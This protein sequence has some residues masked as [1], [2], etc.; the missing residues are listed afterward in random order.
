M[1]SAWLGLAGAIQFETEHSLNAPQLQSS[2][3]IV[4]WLPKAAAA[5][6][7]ITLCLCFF[8]CGP[9][10]ASVPHSSASGVKLRALDPTNAA[11]LIERQALEIM[12]GISP[13]RMFESW[14]VDREFGWPYTSAKQGASYSGL[15]LNSRIV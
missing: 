2:K 8:T 14:V 5:E 11:R 6:R 15:P 7:A 3:R 9:P 10:P 4:A 13:A 12:F 1:V